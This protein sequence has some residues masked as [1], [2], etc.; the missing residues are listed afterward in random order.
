MALIASLTFNIVVGSIFGTAGVLLQPMEQH[1]GVTTEMASAALLGVLVFGALFAPKIGSLAARRSLRSLVASA[2]LML[3]AVWLILAF[4][5]SYA[6]YVAAYALLLGP[7]LSIGSSIVPPTLVTRWFN[8][9]RGMAIGLVHLPIMVAVLPLGCAWLIAQFGLQ[10][11]LLVLGVLPLVT[12]LPASFLIVDWPPGE[13]PAPV[14][15]ATTTG[16]SA[17]T[18]TMMNLLKR[19][20]FW[21]LAL[22]IGIPNTSST[23]LG[24][25]LV[26]MAKSWGVTPLA[27]A[28]LTSI[29]SLV[30]M[31]GS[32]LLGM[33]ADRIGGTRTLMVI[34]A[35]DA[36]LWL[37]FL[38]GLPYAGLA[39]VVGL[40]GLFGA[41]TVP[42][43]SKALADNY[44]KETFSRGMGLLVPMTLPVMFAG[45]IGP[46]TAVRIYGDYTPVVLVMSIA[47]SLTALLIF[48]SSRTKPLSPDA[49]VATG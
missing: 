18:V 47:F 4:T 49:V 10:N 8:R 25:H 32:V 35:V 7:T 33:L 6:L 43:C 44:G 1:L 3:S 28:G 29:M 38:V 5:K 46:G 13:E 24:L 37:L 26:S 17:P 34:A 31:L 14:M 42:A 22:A 9:N 2:A 16:R 30:G 39:T 19:P 36:V 15:A 45:L 20:G 11:T 12:L 21:I 40:I 27:A 23:M 48:L 41:G